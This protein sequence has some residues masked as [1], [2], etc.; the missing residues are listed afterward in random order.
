MIENR[1]FETI[2]C[3]DYEVFNLEYHKKRISNTIGRNFLLEEYIYPNSSELL[4]CK[5]T[6]TKDEI[7]NISYDKYIPKNINSFKL[8]YDDS[9]SYKYKSYNRKEIDDLV[10]QKENADEIIIV[11]NNLITDTSIANIAIYLDDIW[12]TPK[13]PL[14]E[15]T[16]KN[17]YID[18]NILTQ[19]DITVDMLL[20]ANKIALLNAMVDFKI[21]DNFDIIQ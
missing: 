15:G 17:R 16:T 4:K 14:L 21:L 10:S 2:K 19:K 13:I 18:N 11:K 7:I 6:Y 8:I 12:I 1:F 9:I 5:L 3:D 20:K